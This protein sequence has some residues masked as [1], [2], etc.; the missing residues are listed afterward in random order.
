MSAKLIIE[1]RAGEV[2][3]AAFDLHGRAYAAFL[4]RKYDTPASVR[5][6][7]TYSGRLTK[8]APAQGGGFAQVETGEDVFLRTS[9]LQ[10][11]SEGA[12]IIVEIE[13]EARRGKL[14]RGRAVSELS[15]PVPALERWR[16]ALPVQG[17]LLVQYVEPGQGEVDAAFDEAMS[18]VLTLAGGGRL[19]LIETPALV[20]IDIDTA[21]RDDRGRAYDRAAA[22]NTVAAEEAARQMSLRGLGG[23]LVLDCVAPLRKESGR[24][25]KRAFQERFRQYSARKVDV[26]APSPFGLMEAVLAW[27]ERPL[28]HVLQDETGNDTPLTQLLSAIH[29]LERALVM[30]RMGTYLLRLPAA[31]ADLSSQVLEGCSEELTNRYGGRFAIDVTE[32]AISEVSKR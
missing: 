10:G 32:H 24:S 18:G 16:S 8:L 23:A 19:Q 2:R 4:K 3:A 7:N 13:S 9:T 17:D 14:A 5:W 25:I 26:L 20:A 1:D 28:A 27:R 6:G 30:D 21:G 22:V 11:F 31:L 12:S 29:Q 15:E